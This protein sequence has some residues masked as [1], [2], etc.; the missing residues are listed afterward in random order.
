MLQPNL[1]VILV[2]FLQTMFFCLVIFFL[3]AR[4]E[5]LGKRNCCE[6][7]FSKAVVVCGGEE[8]F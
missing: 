3:V 1:V 4:Y 7:V 8:V 6:L 5:A 2:L